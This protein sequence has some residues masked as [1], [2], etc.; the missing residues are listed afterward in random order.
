MK[1]LGISTFSSVAALLILLPSG[2]VAQQQGGTSLK[3]QLVGT[4]MLVSCELPAGSAVPKYCNPANGS[5]AFSGSGRFTFFLAAKD[6]SKT[7]GG[8]GPVVRASVSPED[9]KAVGEGVAAQ[10]G[11]YTLD[12]TTKTLTRH[13]EAAFFPRND[14]TDAKATISINGDELKTVNPGIT[15]TWRRTR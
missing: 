8:N 14:G 5:I 13:I 11:T 15:N 9:Y 12:E 10:F 2:S 7:A 4:W 1:N 6:R 3:Q